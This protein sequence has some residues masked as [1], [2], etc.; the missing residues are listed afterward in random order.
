MSV[1]VKPNIFTPLMEASI[2]V[3]EEI[4]LSM[5]SSHLACRGITKAS[6]IKDPT[7]ATVNKQLDCRFFF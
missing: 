5:A 3:V 7:S 1:D 2:E 6:P 4:R